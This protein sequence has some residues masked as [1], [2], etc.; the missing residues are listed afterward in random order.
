MT[1]GSGLLTEFVLRFNLRNSWPAHNFLSLYVSHMSTSS[2]QWS[3][4]DS[5]TVTQRWTLAGP[6]ANLSP[7]WLTTVDPCKRHLLNAIKLNL[8]PGGDSCNFA[9]STAADRECCLRAPQKR[10]YWLLDRAAPF[11][12]NP[13]F[14]LMVNALVGKKKKQILGKHYTAGSDC[15]FARSI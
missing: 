4:G 13:F 3:R 10:T 8:Q 2:S 9:K 6:L 5:W 11:R 12:S 1:R 14:F 7:N 15:C